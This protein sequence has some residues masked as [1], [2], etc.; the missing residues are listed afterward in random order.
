MRRLISI[1]ALCALALTTQV[2]PVTAEPLE[3]P[4]PRPINKGGP[5]VRLEPV[6]T[7]LTAPN[8]GISAPGDSNRLFVTDQDGILWAIDLASGA[9]TVFLDVSARL[10]PL[11]AFGPGTFDERGLLGLA[12]HPDYPNNG[13]LYTFTSEPVSG[14]A[15]FSTMPPGT[16]PNHQSVIAEWQVPNPSA[17]AS[18]VDPSTRRELL[19]IDKPQFNH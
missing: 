1:V 4:I 2:L 6:A 19:R 18:V 7:G 13:L 10:V 11:G 8:W 3:D 5:Q 16:P 14:P 17:A 15:D 12:F 9:K